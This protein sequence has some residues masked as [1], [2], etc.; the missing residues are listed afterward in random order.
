MLNKVLY[1]GLSIFIL[2]VNCQFVRNAQDVL[3]DCPLNY[4]REARNILNGVFYPTIQHYEYELPLEC[5][6]HPDW[7]KFKILDDNRRWVRG[8]TGGY[9]C[10]LD[11]KVFID[12]NYL[13]KHFKKKHHQ[14][15]QDMDS[16][17][18]GD[19]CDMFSCPSI[20]TVSDKQL[21]HCDSHKMAQ[22][23]FVCSRIINLCF[24]PGGSSKNTHVTYLRNTFSQLFCGHLDCSSQKNIVLPEISS[25]PSGI[26]IAAMIGTIF[27]VTIWYWVAFLWYRYIQHTYNIHTIILTSHTMA[28]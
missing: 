7:D 13:D 23:K 17:C 2:S 10:S 28:L 20:K 6:L 4:T 21:S 1:L 26:W 24:N 3:Q 19:Y 27:I 15:F 18:L 5:P 16:I 14:L 25:S 12:E 22:R 8:K 11:S 9:K